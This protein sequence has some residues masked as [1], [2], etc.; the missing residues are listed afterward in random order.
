MNGLPTKSSDGLDGS[1]LPAEGSP[2]G[3]RRNDSLVTSIAFYSSSNLYRRVLGLLY[4]LLKPKILSP[5]LYGLWNLLSIIPNYGEYLD[6]GSREAM[7]F[8]VPYHEARHE[9]EEVRR[10]KGSVLIGS[11]A[12]MVLAAMGITAVALLPES[13]FNLRVGLVAMAAVVVVQGYVDYRFALL[14]ANQDF[15]LLSKANYFRASSLVFFGIALLYFFGLYGACAAMVISYMATTAYLHLRQ[16]MKDETVFAFS[17]FRRMIMQ[18]FPIMLFN[19]LM[20]LLRSLDRIIVASMLGTQQLGYYSIAVMFFGF[21]M[22]IPGATREVIE[23]M[24]MRRLASDS[25]GENINEYFLKPIINSAYYLPFVLSGFIFLVPVLIDLF[26]PKYRAGI[27]STQ[28]LLFGGYF[29]ALSYPARGVLVA[30]NLQVMALGLAVPALAVE[31][32]VI[33]ALV[34]GGWGLPGVSFGSAIASL[35]YFILVLYFISA[36]FSVDARGWRRHMVGL[37]WPSAVML[38]VFPALNHATRAVGLDLIAAAAVNL[39][40]SCLVLF[41]L[42]QGAAR[43]YPLLSAVT[44]RTM[45]KT[46]GASKKSGER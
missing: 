7:R 21:L 43:R 29:L 17:V 8:A 46:F 26:L 25:E 34:K 2:G 22:Q 1:A 35:I 40:V 5:E 39:V 42:V 16:P 11:L 10:I 19:L 20:L 36:R 33:V 13:D 38:V 31:L 3:E 18:G 32:G 4:A 44:P 14:K 27:V 41:A 45:M 24:L 9:M 30:K 23:P 15:R 6:L 28:I 37:V 12:L